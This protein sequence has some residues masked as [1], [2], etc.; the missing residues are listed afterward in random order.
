MNKI[1]ISFLLITSIVWGKLDKN[2]I[3]HLDNLSKE[4]ALELVKELENSDIKE[5]DMG[6]YYDSDLYQNIIPIYKSILTKKNKNIKINL[7]SED[8]DLV[9]KTIKKENNNN[10]ENARVLG[11]LKKTKYLLKLELLSFSYDKKFLIKSTAKGFIKSEIIDVKSR[12]IIY[13]SIKKIDLDVKWPYKIIAIISILAFILG[14]ILSIL[15]KRY[16]TLKIMS[17]TIV[18][19][20]LINFFYYLI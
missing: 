9:I 12:N 10:Y 1:I 18:L 11:Q 15:T 6:I 16:Y 4:S 13:S 3:F 20:I 7:L 14:I 8:Y 5:Y 2:I 17:F 19:I